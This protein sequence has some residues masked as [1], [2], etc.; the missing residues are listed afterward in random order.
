MNIR[1]V[2][3]RGFVEDVLFYTKTHVC[4]KKKNNLK[5]LKIHDAC[6]CMLV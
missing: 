3:R 6:V 4:Y 2:S 1:G 5:L